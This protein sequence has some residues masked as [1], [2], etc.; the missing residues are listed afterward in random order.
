MEGRASTFK[1]V[2][3]D[4]ERRLIG[5]EYVAIDTE[6]TGVDLE[7]EPD[8]FEESALQRLDKHCRIAERYT[9]IQ[10]GLTVVGHTAIDGQ[11]SC[12][13][14]NLFAFPY[15][16]PE[17]LGREPGF[18]CQA[19]ALQFNSQHRVNF[20]TWIGDGIPYMSREDERRYVK[21]SGSRED[22]NGLEDKVGLLKLWKAL[23]A[24]R[25]PF[26]VHCP[27][28]LF[29]LLAAFE[30]R[31]LPHN[32]PKALAMMIRQCTPKVYDTAHL[33]GVLGRFKRLGLVKFFEDAKARYED[34]VR[35][36]DGHRSVPPLSFELE[37]ETAARYSQDNGLAHEAGFDSM[38]TAQLFAYLRAIQPLRVKEAA[39]RLFLFKSIEFFDLDKA[40]TEGDIG[41]SMFDLTRV[42]LLIAELDPVEGSEAPRL[43]QAAGS[44]CKWVDNSHLLVIIRASGGAAVRKAAELAAQVH[45]V[46]SWKGFDDWR[47][48]QASAS[49]EGR[50]R[51]SSAR[52]FIT[53]EDDEEM[54]ALVTNGCGHDDDR[55]GMW[56]Q[57]RSIIRKWR[58]TP[59]MLGA[60][61]TFFLLLLATRSRAQLLEAGCRLIRRFRWR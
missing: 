25:L 29:F 35:N 17:L 28:D 31:P 4:F 39:N 2:L 38:L 5:A 7:G 13:S 20:N 6:L 19:S 60:S 41:V 37:S 11:L 9:L 43:I 54:P 51:P 23:C 24:A 61:T 47:D 14:Y 10:V 58:W 40:V 49:S 8:S 1:K 57:W 33:H 21:A 16:G 12:A 45:G 50:A 56:P 27:L 15:V 30:R 55:C 42:T 53:F 59:A 46:L 44:Q 34:L 22:A 32:D 26:V 52:R 18:V 3:A 48:T 36:G